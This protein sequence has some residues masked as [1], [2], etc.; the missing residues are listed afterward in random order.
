MKRDHADIK[1]FKRYKLPRNL[2]NSA[3]FKGLY[4]RQ[5]CYFIVHLVFSSKFAS[6]AMGLVDKGV[7]Q[8][9]GGGYS[10]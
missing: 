8:G 1:G 6:A 4:D 9:C 5:G 7:Y 3:G 2:V 10:D